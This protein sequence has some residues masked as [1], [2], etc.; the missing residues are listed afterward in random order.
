MNITAVRVRKLKSTGNFEHCAVEA[1]A[2]VLDGDDPEAIRSELSE[3]VDTAI[4][5]ERHAVDVGRLRDEAM[6]DA[7]YW[8]NE[9]NRVKADYERT[10]KL[11]REHDQ[12]IAAAVDKGLTPPADI[13][14]DEIPF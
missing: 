4:R 3:W 13:L 9:R 8:Q 11:L 10:Y 1:E 12:F 2:S 7:V 6:H 14:S 5:Q